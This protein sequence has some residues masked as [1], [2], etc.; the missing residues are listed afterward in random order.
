MFLL[1]RKTFRERK[2][3]HVEKDSIFLLV[4]SQVSQIISLKQQKEIDEENKTFFIV[5]F[6]RFAQHF[7]KQIFK[8]KETRHN[9]FLSFPT[10]NVSMASFK[11]HKRS[12]H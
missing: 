3:T 4:V 5:C 6:I 9:S 11:Y 8:K 1:F 10:Q 12:L 7:L 2:Q